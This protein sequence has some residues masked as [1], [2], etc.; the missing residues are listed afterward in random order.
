MRFEA[1]VN[2]K[3]KFQENIIW[4]VIYLDWSGVD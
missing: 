3:K 4:A 1:G 2:Q